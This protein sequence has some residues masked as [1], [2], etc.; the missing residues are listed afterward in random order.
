MAMDK[1]YDWALAQNLG[2]RICSKLD[3]FPHRNENQEKQQ[4]WITGSLALASDEFFTKAKAKCEFYVDAHWPEK[5]PVVWCKEPWVKHGAQWHIDRTGL[6]CWEQYLNW[7]DSIR[8]VIEEAT[9]GNAAEYGTT[10]LIRSIRSLLNR[11]LFAHRAGIEAWRKEWDYWAHEQAGE[12][13]YLQSKKLVTAE[14]L[15]LEP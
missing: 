3:G 2:Y 13:Q 5:P 9:I 6:L 8:S 4:I 7:R 11:H 14:K 1:K 10:W 15:E 12:K